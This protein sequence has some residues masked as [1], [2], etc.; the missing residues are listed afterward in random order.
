MIPETLAGCWKLRTFETHHPDGRVTHPFGPSPIGLVV[1]TPDG[2]ASA[3]LMRPDRIKF[4]DADVPPTAAEAQDALRGFVAYYG[5]CEV[6]E[7]NRTLT[8][9]VEGSANPNWM[10]GDQVRQYELRDGILVLSPPVR[11]TP[12]GPLEMELTWE[13]P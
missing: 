7:S 6:D 13:R 4:T 12:A 2:W 9:H 11:Q 3:H 8:T 10:G 1:V 5:R